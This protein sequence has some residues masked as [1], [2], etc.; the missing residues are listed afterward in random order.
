MLDPLWS[1][2]KMR[3]V[4]DGGELSRWEKTELVA[5]HQPALDSLFV[6]FAGGHQNCGRCHKCL[7]TMT[8][9]EGVGALG[10]CTRFDAP[11]Q[12]AAIDRLPTR[13]PGHNNNVRDLLWHLP[14]GSELAAAWARVVP[15]EDLEG[16]PFARGC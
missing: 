8:A 1:T 5:A 10:R 14:P 16:T 7:L 9:L 6:C 2:S 4:H 12:P 3:F 11:L 15:P 13:P